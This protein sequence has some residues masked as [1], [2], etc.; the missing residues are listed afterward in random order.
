V[1]IAA[2]G[3]TALNL[4][5]GE[6]DFAVILLD[7]GLPDIDGAIVLQR[8]MADD[9]LRSIP[10]II[11]S[12]QNDIDSISKT[13]AAGAKYYLTK[14]PQENYLLAVIRTVLDARREFDGIQASGL[15]RILAE[16]VGNDPL[17][18]WQ[19]L[20]E[21]LINAVEHGNLGITY[22]EKSLLILEAR[23]TEEIERR[24]RDPLYASLQV[25]IHLVRSPE[26]LELT[27][28]DQGAGFEWQ[29]FMDYSKDRAFDLH[30]RGVARN[31]NTVKVKVANSPRVD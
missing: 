3:E 29:E 1:T 2:D 9:Q 23:W 6:I 8:I 15:A 12:W 10:V 20:Q 7:L 28:E 27:I 5:A 14:P 21:L 24:Q 11:L 4:L 16:V 31:G 22:K 25:S 30:G 26:G 17:R 18:Y 19:G 13:M